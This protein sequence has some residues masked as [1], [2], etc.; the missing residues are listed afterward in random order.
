MNAR[1]SKAPGS[2]RPS[3]GL[4]TVQVGFIPLVDCASLVVAAEQGFAEAEGLDLVLVREASWASIRDH[5][6]LGYL[7]AAHMLAGMPIAASLGI[8][9]VRVP[10]YAPFSLGLNGNGIEI[11]A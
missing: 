5:L 6:N 11:R 7:D 8:G 2:G 3:G 4:R 9:H 10:T 1:R